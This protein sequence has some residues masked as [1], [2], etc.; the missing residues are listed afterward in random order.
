[1]HC[2][3]INFINIVLVLTK[4]F[5]FEEKFGKYENSINNYFANLWLVEIDFIDFEINDKNVCKIN[6]NK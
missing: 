1:M 2:D 5:Y 3:I 4:R 6:M